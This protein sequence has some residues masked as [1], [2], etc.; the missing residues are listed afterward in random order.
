M[1]GIRNFSLRRQLFL[2]ISFLLIPL[3]AAVTWSG[4]LSFRERRNELGQQAQIMASTIAAF[5]D[6]DAQAIADGLA[7]IPVPEDAVV[8]VADGDG[9]LPGRAGGRAA[10]SAAASSASPA[11]TPGAPPQRSF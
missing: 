7:R 10:R 4:W 2:A 11:R 5:V 1:G 9:R 8:V 3:F 6:G